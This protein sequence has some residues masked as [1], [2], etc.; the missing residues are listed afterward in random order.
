MVQF[1]FYFIVFK[2]LKLYFLVNKHLVIFFFIKSEVD[3]NFWSTN[4]L[5]DS[6]KY[7]IAKFR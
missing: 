5:F 6:I 2:K 3:N 4:G 7:L 1:P